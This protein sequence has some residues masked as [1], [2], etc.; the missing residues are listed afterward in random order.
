M[1]KKPLW[2]VLGGVVI[3]AV[4]AVA[5]SLILSSKKNEDNLNSNQK[6]DLKGV[7]LVYQYLDNKIN[8]EFMVFTEDTVADY[9]GGK[10]E[11]FASSSYTFADG[12]LSMPDISKEFT[13][14]IISDNCVFL[15][16]PDTREWKLARV[17]SSLDSIPE[18]TASSLAGEYDVVCVVGEKRNNEVMVFDETSLTDYRDGKEYL[19]CDYSLDESGRL[20]HAIDIGQDFLVYL[21]SNSLILIEDQTRYV[22]ELKK[23]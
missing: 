19:K 5:I 22:W 21:N 15:V 14:R 12:K 17:A 11:P 23:R 13:V 6:L 3:I 7:W 10:Q 18:V 8:D 20:L 2:L 4:F 9:R 1:K 16:E